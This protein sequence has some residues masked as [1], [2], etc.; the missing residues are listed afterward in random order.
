MD[1]LD[2]ML[3]ITISYLGRGGLIA[4]FTGTLKASRVSRIRDLKEGWRF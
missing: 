3:C 4:L 1:S 2:F